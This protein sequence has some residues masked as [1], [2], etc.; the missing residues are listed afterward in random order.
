MAIVKVLLIAAY[1]CAPTLLLRTPILGCSRRVLA[2]WIP[3]EAGLLVRLG[4]SST[5]VVALAVG[6]GLL[7]FRSR[8]DVLDVRKA[9]NLS[10]VDVKVSVVNF[11]LFA[12]IAVP[13]GLIL[14]FLRPDFDAAALWGAPAMMGVIFLFNALPEEILFRGLIQ[15]WIEKHIAMRTGSLLIS[16]VIFGASHLNNG[17]PLPNYRYMLMASIAGV[18]YGLAWRSRR[19]VLTSSITHTLVN[20]CWNLFFR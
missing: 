13:L 12:A 4:L 19:N 11:L 6:A 10:T 1:V 16:S 17:S 2:L 3:V 7:A 15:N 5:L 9:F 8:Q 20:T 18:F 14:G